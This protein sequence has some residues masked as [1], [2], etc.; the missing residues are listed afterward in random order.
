MLAL[1]KEHFMIKTFFRRFIAVFMLMCCMLAVTSCQPT[2]EKSAV[3]SKVNGDFE[4]ALNAKPIESV[5]FDVPDS[6]YEVFDAKTENVVITVDTK[7]EY[8]NV[9]KIPVNEYCPGEMTSALVRQIADC[10]MEEQ[11]LYERPLLLTKS[12]LLAE[13]KEVENIL[14]ENRLDAEYGN[15]D[16]MV[17][18]IQ[19]TRYE[20]LKRL[21]NDAPDTVEKKEATLEFRPYASFLN[22]AEYADTYATA[23]YFAENG[24]ETAMRELEELESINDKNYASSKM[25]CEA[26]ASL[27]GGYTGYISAQKLS[28]SKTKSCGV[29]FDKGKALG[30]DKRPYSIN[31]MGYDVTPLTIGKD[32]ALKMT[33]AAIEELGYKDEFVLASAEKIHMEEEGLQSYYSVEY[34]R[35]AIPGLITVDYFRLVSADRT[36]KFRPE[37]GAEEISFLVTDDGI[38]SFSL[39]SPLKKVR[40]VNSSV[41]I[42]SFDEIYEIFKQYCTVS[43]DNVMSVTDY[44]ENGRNPVTYY[45]DKTTVKFSD[46]QL[47]ALRV[48]KKD[49]TTHYYIIPVWVFKGNVVKKKSYPDSAQEDVSTEPTAVLI[50]AV[51]GSIINS[52]DCY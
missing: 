1:F 31:D 34:C 30:S 43:Y 46:V 35:N 49:D 3:Q 14:N 33:D 48:V 27:S 13:I 15:N 11:T 5:T 17:R 39:E 25:W 8:P 52:D 21:Y 44:G 38:I 51:D 40:T 28:M 22:Q 2:P 26:V 4:Q 23:K 32:E 41:G 24:D 50:N 29:G 36:G 7:P 45:A 42:K 12:E 20:E 9:E 47:A 37:Y 6:I 16:E 18:A 19:G 10:F